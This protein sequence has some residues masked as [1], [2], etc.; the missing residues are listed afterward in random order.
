VLAQYLQVGG[1]TTFEQ[2]SVEPF[3][4]GGL[5]LAWFHPSSFD[6]G[7]AGTVQPRAAW[8]FAFHLG[9]GS[10]FWISEKLGIRLQA[11]FLFPVLFTSGAFLS[12]PS[13]ASFQVHAGIPVVQGDLT[14]GID[15][16]P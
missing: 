1:L 9:G 7:A 5:G 6:A 14:V 13:G 11:R 4:S 16:S 15:L 3:L 8:V 10:R 2:G 12:G